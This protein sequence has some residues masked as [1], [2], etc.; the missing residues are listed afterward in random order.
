[1]PEPI[2]QSE[3]IITPAGKIYHLDLAPE[4][5]AD[6]IVTVGDPGRVAEV[7]RYF[8]R[9]ECRAHHREFVSHTGYLGKKR[10]TVVGTGIGPDN[11]DIALNE[12]DALA[13]IDFASRLP[14]KNLRQL[15]IV[16]MGTCGSLQEEVPV[17]NFVIS[18][19]SIG[20]DNL[21]QYYQHKNTDEEAGIL[22][23]LE[24]HLRLDHTLI[25]PY[26][27]SCSHELLSRFNDGYIKGI[28][29][30]CP[31]FYAPQG[32]QLRAPIAFPGLIDS[33][34]SF[35]YHEERILNFE[36]ETSA[37]Y[38]LGSILGHLCLSV[39]TVVA[40]RIS[41]TFSQDAASSIEKMIVKTL[42]IIEKI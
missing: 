1:M 23:K 28:T 15:T 33:L 27:T 34:A 7:S 4:E 3:L 36:M 29:V 13:N 9:I 41:K 16:R 6:T 19:R 22:D 25:K 20:L 30:T 8:D 18:T 31:G 10:I 5:L 17:D 11:I 12:I 2:G 42:E 38:G 35:R 26:L 37:I 32:R 40:N 21:L 24:K 14:K 39:N